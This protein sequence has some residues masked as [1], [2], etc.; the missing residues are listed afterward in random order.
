MYFKHS[1]NIY[2]DPVGDISFWWTNTIKRSQVA[3]C[4]SCKNTVELEL[5]PKGNKPC[6]FIGRT[7]TEAPILWP[8]GGWSWLFGKDLDAGKEWR[9]KEKGVTED[10]IVSP[11]QWTWIWANSGREWTEE[12]GVLQSTGSQRVRQDLVTEEQWQELVYVWL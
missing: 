12:S 9:Q 7:D 3:W 6:I 1:F 8:P 10:E 5:V 11:T 2:N 4:R